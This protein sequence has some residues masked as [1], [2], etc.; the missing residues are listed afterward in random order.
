MLCDHDDCHGQRSRSLT[1]LASFLQTNGMDHQA[2]WSA[3]A[4]RVEHHTDDL[5]PFMLSL[6]HGRRAALTAA[7]L[8]ATRYR[9]GGRTGWIV[10]IDQMGARDEELVRLSLQSDGR[11]V[12]ETEGLTSG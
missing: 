6:H 5:A 1:A 8:I 3:P 2:R 9:L 4:Y 10:V 12:E 11:G 7:L